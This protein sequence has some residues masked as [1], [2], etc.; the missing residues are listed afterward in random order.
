MFSSS[1]LEILGSLGTVS[2]VVLL[3]LLLFSVFSWG[4]IIYKIRMFR[5][6]NREEEQFL[7]AYER[8]R[9]SAKDLERLKKTGESLSLSPSG[10]VFVAVTN[11][12]D[13]QSDILRNRDLLEETQAGRYPNR[14][15]L[16]KFVQYI[17]QGQISDLER[18]LPFLAT[19]GNISPFIGLF[20]TVVGVMNAFG[21][22]GAQGSA[23]IAAVAPGVA[24]AL[25][26]T[27]AGLFAAI[28]AVVAYNYF[29][30]KIRKNVYRVE[31]FSIE[32]LNALDELAS[33]EKEAEV[34]R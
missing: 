30:T 8:S 33:E 22:I 25:V 29:L 14:H 9:L 6:A 34:V 4:I 15:Y 18:Y 23:S 24:E 20:G 28:P 5:S 26:A 31:A 19:T 17:I 16:E 12:V 2:I 1:P 32:F 21:K 13:R 10:A 7:H 11:K 3:I 27:A